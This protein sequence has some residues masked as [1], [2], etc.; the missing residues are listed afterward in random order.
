MSRKKE[1]YVRAEIPMISVNP[2]YI[3]L[4]TDKGQFT[5]RGKSN[6][7]IFV[8]PET[9]EVIHLG[10]TAKQIAAEENLKDNDTKGLISNKAGKR[11]NQALSWFTAMSATHTRISRNSVKVKNN[12]SFITLTLS[13]KQKHDDIY[14]KSKLLNA[15]LVDL[16][17]R[18]FIVSYLWRAEAQI[19]GN[20]HFHIVINRY[21]HYSHIRNIWNRIQAEHGYIEN[22]SHKAKW[23]SNA[24]PPSTEIKA[25]YKCKNI[26]GY[27]S[28]YCTK[29]LNAMKLHSNIAPH[30]LQQV[31]KASGRKNKD[32][33]PE[34]PGLLAAK[35]IEKENCFMLKYDSALIN[36]EQIAALVQATGAIVMHYVD[37]PLRAIEGRHWFCSST[38]TKM[39]NV[40]D[41][42]SDD[43]IT[44]LDNILVKGCIKY[45]KIVK[46]YVT[47][48]CF[49][50]FECVQNGL[51]EGFRQLIRL[52]QNR[53][54]TYENEAYLNLL[55]KAG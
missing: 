20:I 45:T 28:K 11:I 8:N 36:P 1:K 6:D 31:V 32:G 26:A 35:F 27:L 16:R 13:A 54:V 52:N 39:K 9:F 21:I 7:A 30:K 37:I 14:I 22:Y 5:G 41:V 25:V 44:D 49:N 53:W 42:V 2:N 19:N 18:F 50:V 24:N 55:M 38:L 3:S 47:V 51:F 33:I 34:N 17:R 48:I 43:I 40:S 15:F 29:N 46:D 10:R 23:G 12:L 4:Y